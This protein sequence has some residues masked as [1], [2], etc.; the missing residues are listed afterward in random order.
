MDPYLPPHSFGNYYRITMTIPIPGRGLVHQ[1]R[2]Q[3]K[4]IDRDY[5][6]KLQDGD[7]HLDFLKDSSYRVLLKDTKT[8]GGIEEY[9]SLKVK[10]MTKFEADQELLAYACMH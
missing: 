6:I 2:D 8:A 7:D 4:K 1:V 9:L 3:I 5:V 10:D